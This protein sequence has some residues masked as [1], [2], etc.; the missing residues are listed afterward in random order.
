MYPDYKNLDEQEIP[1]GEAKLYR[2]FSR[3]D[4]KFHIF[5]S[6]SWITRSLRGPKDGEADF[7][8]CHPEKGILVI[9]VKGGRVSA[10][11]ERDLWLSVDHRGESHTIKD[12]F[13]QAKNAKFKVLEKLKEHQDWRQV[14]LGYFTLGHAAFFPDVDT[15]EALRGPNAPISIIGD[16]NSLPV[17]EAWINNVF[18]YWSSSEEDTNPSIIGAAGISF[19]KKIFARVVTARPLLAKKLEREEETRLD[20]TERQISTLNMFSKN[21]RVVVSGG[22]GTG[23]TVL[24]VEKA[25]R[26][27]E[28]GYKTLLTCYNVRLAEHLNKVCGTNPNLEVI[29]FHRL[30]RR[31]IN[32]AKEHSGRDILREQITENPTADKWT[33]HYPNALAYSLDVVD[34]QFDAIV[35]DE[36]QDFGEYFWFPIELML[37]DSKLSPLYIFQDENQDIYSRA[38]TFPGDAVPVSLTFNCRNTKKIHKAAYGYYN[39]PAI[40]PPSVDGD[41]IEILSDEDTTRQAKKI[42][43]YVSKLFTTERILPEDITIL[44]A[45]NLRR[46]SYEEILK[47]TPLHA[48]YQWDTTGHTK[49][50]SILVD[51]VARYKGLE[52]KIIVI[53]GLDSLEQ[54]VLNE[55]LYI[56]FSRAKSVLALCGS[57]E[58]CDK[59]LFPM[60]NTLTPK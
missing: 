22:A 19:V 49:R 34:L 4:D 36:G 51:T 23:K 28:F 54:E 42:R 44:I 53:W 11:Y 33:H 6:V 39:G 14:R 21:R 13:R 18:E 25:K 50:N 24:A 41:E 9:E 7:L 10:D 5:H 57:K 46:K 31:V 59:V 15:A 30:C 1:S 45:D 2:A 27:A 56:G 29:G 32:Q 37:S 43:E 20:L 58:I 48:G 55:T 12:P 17:L 40:E 52:N 3:L 16:Q 38:S 26:L 35:I 60:G 47:K 8:V